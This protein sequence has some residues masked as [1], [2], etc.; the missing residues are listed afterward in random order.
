MKKQHKLTWSAGALA[1]VGFCALAAG[2]AQADTFNLTS[3]HIS[4]GCPAAGTVFGTVTLTQVGTGVNFS[5]SLANGSRFV[6]TGSGGGGLFVFNDAIAGSTITT[7]ATTPTTPAGGLTGFTNVS[8]LIHADG[9]GDWSAIVECTVA[10]DCNGGSAPTMTSLTFTVTNA[11]LAQLEVVNNGGNFFVADILCGAS[12][13]G[14]AGQTG[15][16][17]VSPSAVPIPGAAWLFGTALVGMGLLVRRKRKAQA[18]T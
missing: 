3:C 6:E 14:C 16:V 5:V 11:T 2:P 12:V 8:P 15:P 10:G 13:T 4:T 1:A 17:D 7:I 18:V 9:T